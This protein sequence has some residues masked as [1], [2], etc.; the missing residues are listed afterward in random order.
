MSCVL[1]RGGQEGLGLLDQHPVLPLPR[2]QGFRERGAGPTR[3]QAGGPRSRGDAPKD[4]EASFRHLGRVADKALSTG[5]ISAA[6]PRKT[7]RG[8][9][10]SGDFGDRARGP[11]GR[12][13]LTARIR[14]ED[15]L[16]A[17]PALLDRSWT[18]HPRVRIFTPSV[19]WRSGPRRGGPFRPEQVIRTGNSGR[20]DEEAATQRGWYRPQ[21]KGDRRLS[22]RG[23]RKRQCGGGILLDISPATPTTP[24][25]AAPGCTLGRWHP[26]N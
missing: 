10:R 9:G 15:A 16:A 12:P 4:M 26:G 6:P 17:T 21:Q 1:P 20:G 22:R 25:A 24:A 19:R 13:E 18:G 23:R 7:V 5:C 3:R 11:P 8:R 14:R 2:R